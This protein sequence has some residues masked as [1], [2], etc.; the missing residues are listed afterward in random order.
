MEQELISENSGSAIRDDGSVEDVVQDATSAT[1]ESEAVSEVRTVIRDFTGFVARLQNYL[2]GAEAELFGG[3]G[4]PVNF[5]ELD[6]T[7]EYVRSQFSV[8]DAHNSEDRDTP[9]WRL[10]RRAT[11]LHNMISDELQ[12]IL[13]N[14][15]INTTG[16]QCTDRIVGLSRDSPV[17]DLR[18]FVHDIDKNRLGSVLSI[19]STV[20]NSICFLEAE[21]F[22]C[23]HMKKA[24]LHSPSPG[25]RLNAGAAWIGRADALWEEI[26]RVA[27]A[28]QMIP[29]DAI[30]QNAGKS[31]CALPNMVSRME[32]K[33]Y[34]L[35]KKLARFMH[36]TL[37]HG[38]GRCQSRQSSPMETLL[39][40]SIL[41]QPTKMRI[42]LVNQSRKRDAAII[43]HRPTRSSILTPA[44]KDSLRDLELPSGL[45][46]VI[47]GVKSM[48]NNDD[49]ENF[50][51]A[52]SDILQTLDRHIR[53]L[54]QEAMSED[55][56]RTATIG[57]LLDAEVASFESRIKLA[58]EEIRKSK[59]TWDEVGRKGTRIL[60]EIR[61][62]LDEVKKLD[63]LL[64]SPAASADLTLQIAD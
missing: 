16:P 53:I 46:D 56:L 51:R 13:A 40:T 37:F 4:G 26:V 25:H 49:E 3:K 1:N 9:E 15:A 20:A 44:E 19:Q 31:L 28:V 47:P 10:N 33:T 42:F 50:D 30:P 5:S 52:L 41:K 38:G 59:R 62:T 21:A 18:Q 7:I 48:G 43:T 29:D 17:E 23:K 63:A 55:G 27:K 54:E 24:L 14:G 64:N 60:T 11:I 6:E 58:L 32:M 35:L 61:S 45:Q 34:P 12:Q 2:N 8:Y 22:R 57:S 36:K 39:P